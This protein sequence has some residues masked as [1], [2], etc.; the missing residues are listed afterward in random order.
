MRFSL[1]ADLLSKKGLF[2]IGMIEQQDFV[3]T[4]PDLSAGAPFD[5]SSL[6]AS[7]KNANVPQE[8]RLGLF[9]SLL[10]LPALAR[11]SRA[12]E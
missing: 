10:F 11:I 6:R 2:E 9:L 3:K 4:E 8:H 5:T 1:R 7:G 12:M